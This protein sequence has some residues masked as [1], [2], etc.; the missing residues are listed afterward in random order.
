M[1][2]GKPNG[3]GGTSRFHLSLNIETELFA[4]KQILSG[5]SSRSPETQQKKRQNVGEHIVGATTEC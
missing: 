4:E 2:K 3:V 1:S 5:Q